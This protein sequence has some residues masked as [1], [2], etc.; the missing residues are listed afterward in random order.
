MKQVF[1]NEASRLCWKIEKRRETPATTFFL[2][3]EKV[4]KWKIKF[5]PSQPQYALKKVANLFDFGLIWAKLH[6]EKSNQ[7]LQ[8]LLIMDIMQLMKDGQIVILYRAL[9]L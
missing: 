2:T 8:F 3:I 5:F 1:W 7:L 4:E 6:I 9:S